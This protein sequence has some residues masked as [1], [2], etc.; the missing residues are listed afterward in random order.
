MMLPLT[1]SRSKAVRLARR[2]ANAAVTESLSPQ[3]AP[4]APMKANHTAEARNV[5]AA[6]AR[7]NA[8]AAA[9]F[10]GPPLP[11]ERMEDI[12]FLPQA[13]A[14]VCNNDA[15]VQRIAGLI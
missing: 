9:D 7:T 8:Q 5:D 2:P 12:R 4:L 14:A 15:T 1:V 6:T 10:I 3:P 13:K 11:K